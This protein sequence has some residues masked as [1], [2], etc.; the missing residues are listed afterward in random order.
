M[1]SARS[2][3]D[4][5]YVF[6]ADRL[7]EAILSA[8]ETALDARAIV[9]F[10]PSSVDDQT[11]FERALK[12]TTI[13]KFSSDRLSD[14]V[15]K[16]FLRRDAFSIMTHGADGLE[17]RRGAESVWCRAVSA[18]VVRDTCGSG[19]MVSIGVIDWILTR[20]VRGFN[21]GSLGHLLVGVTAGQ[22]LA[23]ANCAFE[24]ARGVFQRRG[25]QFARMVLDDDLGGA[26]SQLDFFD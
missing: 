10:E 14:S 12:L 17:V 26:L 20:Q 6:Y 1:S 25:P 4:A 11:L 15:I 9:Y 22:R 7:S 18:S 2:V 24:G 23:A 19:D 16:S 3:L 13:L 8:M 5:C 21:N